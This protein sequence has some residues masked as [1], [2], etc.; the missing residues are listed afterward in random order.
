MS[1]TDQQSDTIVIGQLQNRKKHYDD[2]VDN[3]TIDNNNSE[4]DIQQQRDN[5]NSTATAQQRLLELKNKLA[6]NRRLNNKLAKSERENNDNNNS[7]TTNK[8]NNNSDSDNEHNDK[9][10]VN[11][12]TTSLYY[13][14]HTTVSIDN[15]QYKHRQ[16][17][18]DRINRSQNIQNN[19]QRYIKSH[20]KR[21]QYIND[22]IHNNDNNS[23]TNTDNNDNTHIVSTQPI[24]PLDVLN[25]KPSQHSIDNMLNELHHTESRNKQYSRRRKY[26]V[27]DDKLYIS[28]ENRLFNKK[29][30]KHYDVYTVDIQQNLERGTAM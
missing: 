23:I 22:I 5:I 24:N 6:I 25:H 13:N 1:D 18:Q 30:A 4:T 16:V 27:D 15:K 2:N 3:D 12:N 14:L 26:N 29:I 9:D 21:I 8:L 20:N 19:D 11:N 7:N 17:K 28:E 10:N